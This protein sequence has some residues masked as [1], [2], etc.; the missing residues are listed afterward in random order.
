MSGAVVVGSRL[1]NILAAVAQ[2]Q[3]VHLGHRAFLRDQGAHALADLIDGVISEADY[4][5]RAQ[6]ERQGRH[7]AARQREDEAAAA[8]RRQ[9]DLDA[10]RDAALQARLHEEAQRKQ[11][12]RIRYESSPAFLA[13]QKNRQ[14]L[15]RYGV[16][17][18]I[19]AGDFKHLL[20]ILRQLDCGGRLQQ[21]AVEW[22]K[23]RA[24]RYGFAGVLAA[25]HRR[26]ADV[27]LAEFVQGGDP[28]QAIN[29]SGHLRKCDAATEAI[30]LLATV[31][32]PR[33][34]SDKLK[35]AMLTT[36]GGALRDLGRL[37]EAQQAGQAAHELLAQDYRPCTLL[38]AV[39]IQQGNYALGHDWYRKAEARGAP[40]AGINSEI[41]SLLR[42]MPEEKRLAATAELLRADPVRYQS[43]SMSR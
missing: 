38:G 7:E 17:A 10:E 41:R 19:D 27:C 12:A 29:A 14:L 40:P 8:R 13:R 20:P 36:Q 28:W 3:P 18:Y 34:T 11:A 21:K 35:S 9:A 25:H 37:P 30:D 16:D 15:Q 24:Y 5:A 32:A 22:L 33:L 42:G 23:G 43:L 2:K 6:I 1:N 31:P 4:A 39:H 26:E